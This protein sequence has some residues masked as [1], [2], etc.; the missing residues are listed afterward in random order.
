MSNREKIMLLLWFQGPKTS[1]EIAEHMDMTWAPM[2]TGDVRAVVKEKL[3]Y[4]AFEDGKAVYGLT[5]PG[6]DYCMRNY[7]ARLQSAGAVVDATAEEEAQSADAPSE[8][9]DAAEQ[10]AVVE[11][12]DRAIEETAADIM[13]AIVHDHPELAQRRMIELPANCDFSAE[14]IRI[15]AEDPL[16]RPVS[17]YRLQPVGQ[18]RRHVVFETA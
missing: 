5:R 8:A 7:R 1:E 9:G 17:V 14:A 15:A 2:L 11:T 3:V 16:G 6:R 13:L 4:R 10:D 12:T 18:T